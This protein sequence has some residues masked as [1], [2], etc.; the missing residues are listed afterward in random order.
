MSK[1]ILVGYDPRMTDR[2]PV[3][4]GIAAARFTG[5]ALIVASVQAL[6]PALHGGGHVDGDLL[7]DCTH[8]VDQIKADLA[9]TGLHVECRALQSSSAARALHEAAEELD[10][11]LLVVGSAKESGAGRVRIGST[12]ERL[13]QG[14]PCPVGVVPAGWK[15]TK[16]APEVVGVA[17]ID[18]DEGREALRGAYALAR[19]AGAA[20]RVITVVDH[21][22]MMHLETEPSYVAGKLGKDLLDVE[23]EHRLRVEKEVRKAVEELGDDVPVEIDV[24]VGEPVDT[25]VAI[26]INLDLL[27]CGSR[28]YGPLR[29]VL[30]GSVSRRLVN[31]AH[32]PVVALPRGVKAS[33]ESLVADEAEALA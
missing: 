19:R 9:G 7:D 16:V 25:I 30:L 21:S 2:A 26:T 3:D 4:F 14:A 12:A 23:G 29:A 18:T 6:A 10:A 28:G 1:P 15:S 11:G 20:L 13:L 27:I 22:L 32:C 31:E 5:T 24:S 33:L 8:I 17:Y